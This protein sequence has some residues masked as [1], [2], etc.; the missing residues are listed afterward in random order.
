MNIPINVKVPV[1]N[2]ND[3]TA[4]LVSCK[5]TSGSL[6]SQGALIAELETTKATFEMVAP[7]GGYIQFL[8]SIDDE[9][10][11]GETLCRIHLE[12]PPATDLPSVPELSSRVASP[13]QLDS[14]PVENV[15]EIGASGSVETPPKSE[16]LDLRMERGAPHLQ[17]ST[18]VFS[19]RA[20][21]SIQ[22]LKLDP[23]NFAGL[24]FVRET[25]VRG[26]FDPACKTNNI[27]KTVAKPLVVQAVI[28]GEVG[29]A[30]DQPGDLIKLARSKIYENRELIKADQAVIKSTLHFLCDAG[31]LNV[32]CGRQS[33]PMRRLA[34][35]LFEVAK[36]L[37]KHRTLNAAFYQDSAYIYHQVNIGFAVEM[38][39]GLKVLVIRKAD[40]LDFASLS[41]RFDD[42]LVK[43][44]TNTLKI[45][46]LTGSTFTVTDLSQEGVYSFDPVINNNQ[47]AILGIGGEFTRSEGKCGFMMSC[48][49]DHRLNGGKAVAEFL[50]DLSTRLAAHG[51]SLTAGAKVALQPECARCLR[52]LPQLRG[53]D[54]LL[55]PS[56]EPVGFVCSICFSGY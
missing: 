34:L 36:L 52:T 42:L 5:V 40:S 17:F 26:R 48:A 3:L 38:G 16:M 27:S 9:V 22:E 13:V 10:P 21:A 23:L 8:W 50:R 39:N 37:T 4:K 2:V 33:P 7:A 47:S 45:E 55:V 44:M 56:V 35:I 11:V 15:P 6:V 31:N 41:V 43:Y 24:S 28:P 1:E 32:L 53:L 14:I 46:D 19:Q 51:E 12:W 20:L 54:A 49:F 30:P 29:S 18:P 25:D